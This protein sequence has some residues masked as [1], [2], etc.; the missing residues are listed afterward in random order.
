[1]IL[2]HKGIAAGV[3]FQG[4]N[5]AYKEE[6]QAD[7]QTQGEAGI[8]SAGPEKLPG[9]SVLLNRLIQGRSNEFSPPVVC[10]FLTIKPLSLQQLKS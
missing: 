7:A 1:M 2:R 10:D 3:F 9:L 5:K 6:D 8:S 4:R